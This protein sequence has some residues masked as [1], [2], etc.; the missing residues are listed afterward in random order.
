MAPW[1]HSQ[2]QNPREQ[3]KKLR[4]FAERHE[5]KSLWPK[6]PKQERPVRAYIKPQTQIDLRKTISTKKKTIN[7]CTLLHDI[8]NCFGQK[9]L[10]F[11]LNP[12]FSLPILSSTRWPVATWLLVARTLG[13][14]TPSVRTRRFNFHR[15]NSNSS[16]N[17][18]C[19]SS[20]NNN[21]SNSRYDFLNS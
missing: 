5:I 9:S 13:A 15:N 6:L 18:W 3:Q 14:R 2:R 11:F 4:D 20:S 8:F 17:N 7:A 19:F 12:T 21:N 1:L 16:N 10:E